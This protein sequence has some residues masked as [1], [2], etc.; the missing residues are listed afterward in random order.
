MSG[1]NTLKDR[2]GRIRE[3]YKRMDGRLDISFKR[4][5]KRIKYKNENF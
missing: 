2:M 3:N 1:M 5:P 4:K